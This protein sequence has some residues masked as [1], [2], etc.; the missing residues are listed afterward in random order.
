M[1][2]PFTRGEKRAHPP[3][4]QC[5]SLSLLWPVAP[6]LLGRGP[7]TT[8]N[9]FPLLRFLSS[10]TG[11]GRCCSAME[12][13]AVPGNVWLISGTQQC[14]CLPFTH[15]LGT[16][17]LETVISNKRLYVPPRPW[18]PSCAPVV[19]PCESAEWK[20]LGIC[21]PRTLGLKLFSFNF[22]FFFPRPGIYSSLFVV[23]ARVQE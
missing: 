19:S 23:W 16:C 11:L 6:L 3:L 8:T 9:W 2:W 5:L 7:L 4:P 13:S 15:F 1:K 22:F 10:L 17:C 18:N 14:V 20:M 21:N 12:G